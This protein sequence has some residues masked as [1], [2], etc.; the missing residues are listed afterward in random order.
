[1]RTARILACLAVAAAA[2]SACQA[3]TATELDTSPTT[4]VQTSTPTTVP[5]E[6]VPVNYVGYLHQPVACGA[7]PPAP[8]VDMKFAEPDDEDVTGPI[9]VT[10][11]TSCGPIELLLDPDL[12]PET[13]NSFV[14]LA[15]QGYFNGTVSHRILP[16][17][18]MQAGDPTATGRGEPGYTIPDEFPDTADYTRGVVAMANS[19]AGTTGSQFFIMFGDAAWLP[20]NYTI[21]GHVTDGFATLDAIEQ[22]PLGQGA[23][24]ADPRPSTPLESLFIESITIDR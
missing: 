18:M 14:F 2:L 15:E 20:P 17:F 4:T 8:A 3:G 21:F 7:E 24:S 12:A 1:M 22:I 5:L 11:H 10:L 13:V 9:T 16:G 23:A 19:G 6:T